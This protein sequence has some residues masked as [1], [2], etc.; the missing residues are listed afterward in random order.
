MGF[1]RWDWEVSVSGHVSPQTCVELVAANSVLVA[2]SLV[3]ANS[4][5]VARLPPLHVRILAWLA[6]A[7]NYKRDSTNEVMQ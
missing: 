7:S 1:S 6:A 4:V 2:C 3:A 5:L